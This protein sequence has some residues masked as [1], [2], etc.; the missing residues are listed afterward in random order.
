M[1]VV[2]E[3]RDDERIVRQVCRGQVRGKL[4]EGNEIFCLRRVVLYVGHVDDRIV[5]HGVV[6][7]VTAGIANGGK[8]VSVGFPGFAGGDQL[9]DDIV[10]G[11]RK[12]VRCQSVDE[13]ESLSGGELE[14]VWDRGM[15]VGEIVR[16]QAVLV[17]QAVQVGHGRAG[18]NVGVIV[19]FLDDD[20]DVAK[21]HILSGRR[22]GLRYLS[23]DAAG[24]G[25]NAADQREP[26]KPGGGPNA[27][28]GCVH[29]FRSNVEFFLENSAHGPFRIAR[30]TLLAAS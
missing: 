26:S 3:V 27:W 28:A 6:A 23:S 29:R 15:G 20:E 7:S 17:G 16:G 11:N 9:T 8:I 21:A 14:I 22:R 4:A 18:D 13:R 1:R 30:R 12:R 10:F 5:A 24:Q 19:V 2:A 25:G